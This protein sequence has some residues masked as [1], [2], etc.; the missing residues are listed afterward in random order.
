LLLFGRFCNR[1][2][3]G[4]REFDVLWGTILRARVR[5]SS[6]DLAQELFID[7]PLPSLASALSN[8]LRDF[9][10]VFP[11]HCIFTP[12]ICAAQAERDKETRL[13]LGA[14]IGRKY[15]T[16]RDTRSASPLPRMSD[17]AKLALEESLALNGFFVVEC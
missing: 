3:D 7:S 9:V 2:G 4:I 8:L 13:V 16:W 12:E 1:L 6:V 11:G 5:L 17:S 10:D 14:A 15:L